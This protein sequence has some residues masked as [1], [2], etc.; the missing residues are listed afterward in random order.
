MGALDVSAEVVS[1]ARAAYRP[2]YKRLAS[3]HVANARG[4]L[5]MSHAEYADHL[6]ALL[7]WRVTPEAVEHWERGST[8]P[9]DVLLASV[10]AAQDVLLP[11]GTTSLLDPVPGGFPAGA[12]A[13][14]WVTAYQFA[15]AGMVRFHADIAHV[16][17][18][19]ERQVQVVNHPPEPRTQDRSSPFRNQIEGRLFGRHLIGT[20]RNS[21]DTRYYGSVQLAVLPGETVMDGH[22]TGLASD[23]EVSACRWKWVRLE[24]G[25]MSGVILREP[26]AVWEKVMDRTQDD[27]PLTLADIREEA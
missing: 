19:S 5:G 27:P 10:A 6:A 7:G 13:G 23:I 15:H 22:Y 21:S 26:A 11:E 20:W 14:Q 2:D 17:A 12:L 3:G 4:K 9:G 24:P 8:P 18:V 1:I 25:D 16:T